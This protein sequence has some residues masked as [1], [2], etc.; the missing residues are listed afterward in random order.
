MYKY[1]FPVRVTDCEAQFTDS[2]SKLTA[3]TSSTCL[4]KTSFF[5][6]EGNGKDW[7]A[8]ADSHSTDCI[9]ASTKREP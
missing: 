6:L 5:L 2:L 7:N 3:T 1:V 4:H 8:Y 9:P